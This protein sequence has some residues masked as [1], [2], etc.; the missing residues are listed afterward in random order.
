MTNRLRIIAANAPVLSDLYR[1]FWAFPRHI[2]ACRGVYASC[3]EATA[4]APKGRPFGY[5][6]EGIADHTN[7]ARLT[8]RRNVGEFEASDYPVL[9]WLA[10]AFQSGSSVFDLGGN[11]GLEYYA[12]R[13]F[14]RYPSSLRWVV[15]DLPELCRAGRQLAKERAVTNLEFTDEFAAAEGFD[16][17]LSCGTLQYLP[18]PLSIMLGSLK[19]KPHHV[20]VQR[21]PLYDG[22]TYYTVQNLGYAF[23][24]YRIQNRLE[25][26]ES[27]TALGYAAIDSW[28]DAR[29]CQIP[30]NPS[31]TVH[32][33]HGAY[34][35]LP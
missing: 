32:G 25:L 34:F 35:A 29:E 8:A 6:Q 15:C 10:R 33:Y 21:T 17:L 5:S 30:F 13:R 11:V 4:A 7:P 20:I 26:L 12:Y 19:H 23:S 2:A 28:N 9:V 3:E 31:K 16:I 18:Q 22:P 24:P 1:Y 27:M 14:L